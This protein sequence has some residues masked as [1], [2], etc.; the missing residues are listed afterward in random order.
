MG[1]PYTIRIFVP[2]GDPE[3]LRI[4]DR[5]NWTGLG[6]VF[7]REQWAKIRQRADFSRTGVYILVGYIS[8]DDLPTLYIGQGDVVRPRLENHIQNKEF[9]NKA[10]VFVSS[11]GGLN[12]AHATWLEHALIR[13]ATAAKQSHLDNN[14]EPQE[15]AL[16]EAEKADTG[17][18][19]RE[20]LQILPLVGLNAFEIPKALAEPQT[21]PVDAGSSKAAPGELDTIV[22]PAQKEGFQQVFLGENAWWAIRI[23]GG[24]IPK[25]KYIAAYQTLPTAAITHVAPVARIEPHGDSGKYKLVFSEPAK[26]IGPISFGDAPSGFMQGPRYTTYERLM[27]AKKIT[28]LIVKEKTHAGSG[29]STGELGHVG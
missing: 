1:E 6:I 18:F 9:W 15:P 25:I 14:T 12:R 3:G 13:R 7:P 24:M 4:I 21:T 11:A 28:D 19:L 5:M 20:I 10:I 8:E 27:K 29:A 23:S 26:P 2:D 22:V 17:A 16:S